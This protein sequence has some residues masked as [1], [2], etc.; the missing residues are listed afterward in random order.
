MCPQVPALHFFA[1]E[2]L[3]QAEFMW[4]TPQKDIIPTCRELGV[5]IVAY[6]PLGRGFLTGQIKS[7][8]DLPA[9]DFRRRSEQSDPTIAWLA[10]IGC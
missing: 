2:K 9:D 7:V 4:L 10:Q 6:S 5:G 3:R 8:D 1:S